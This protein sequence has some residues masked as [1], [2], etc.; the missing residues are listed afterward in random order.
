M[1]AVCSVDVKREIGP[2]EGQGR[3]SFECK[4]PHSQ[5]DL[6]DIPAV[7]V[8]LAFDI[9]DASHFIEKWNVNPLAVI[10]NDPD[11]RLTVLTLIQRR[12]RE[13]MNGSAVVYSFRKTRR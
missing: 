3:I 12:F 6:F 11:F 8:A 1:G 4:I 5:G 13:I 7:H 10:E 9:E 2:E